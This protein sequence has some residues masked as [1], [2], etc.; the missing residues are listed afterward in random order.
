MLY[1]PEQSN[2]DFNNQSPERKKEKKITHND[3]GIKLRDNCITRSRFGA[4]IN[5]TSSRFGII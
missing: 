3:E 4:N 2:W 5:L 1:K